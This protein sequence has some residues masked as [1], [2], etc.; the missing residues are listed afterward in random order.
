MANSNTNYSSSTIDPNGGFCTETK[1]YHS[2]RPHAPL[3]SETASLSITDY[4]FSLLRQNSPSPET[5]ALV[6]TATGR[7]IP[8]HDLVI[9]T[10]AL[11]AY[12][13]HRV[14]LA[15]GD[16][17][18]V[19]S[20]NS[21]H[22]PILYLSLFSL[23]VIVSPSNPISSEPEVS[24][25][26]ELCKPVIAFATANT[27][28]KVT[29]I[30]TIL[31][32]SAEFESMMTTRTGRTPRVNI[33]QSDTAA[34]LYSSGTTGNFKGVELTHRNFI[35]SL[36]GTQACRPVRPSSAVILCAVPYFHMYGFICCVRAVAMG[37]GLV[38]MGRFDLRLMIK[39]IGDFRVSHLALAPPIVV[40]MVKEGDFMDG[41]DLSSLEAVVSGG[42]PLPIAVVERFK[43][44]FPKVQL[45]QG[46]GLTES[47]GGVARMMGPNESQRFGASGRLMPYCQ[48]KIVDVE[49]GIGLPPFKQGEFWVRGPTIM[50]GYV[51]DKEA[52]AMILDSEGWLR[53]G[54]ICYFDSEG[55]VYVVDRLK[56]LIKYKGYQIAP[57]E[58]ENLIQ[59]HPDVIDAA[60]VPYPDEE[61]GQVPMAFVVRRPQSTIDETEVK[62]FVARQV[63][64]YKK[65][66]KVSFIGSIPRSAPGKVLR[67]ELIKLALSGVSSKI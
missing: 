67:K 12:L 24:R 64:P 50:K 7:R 15:R 17:A 11:A 1:I 31:L 35:S 14:G 48:A 3:P 27:A 2:L 34:I 4:V 20:P 16:S 53:T 38:T 42:A 40:A 62:D 9:R 32:D 55:F 26:I 56:E 51:N 36:A 43:K 19:L 41:Y 60:V 61:A 52:T 29:S 54:D 6:D 18:F 63:A 39:A 25:Q 66:R 22:L 37:D 13:H 65:I 57:V 59:N 58:L 47:T 44:R 5:A 28:H 33:S 46:Y 30:R 45:T 10:E 49:T 21:I 23:G 8:Y